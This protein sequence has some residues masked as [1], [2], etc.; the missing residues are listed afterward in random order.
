M[1]IY[2]QSA[3]DVHDF[4]WKVAP[5]Q[6]EEPSPEAIALYRRLSPFAT[7]MAMAAAAM[8]GEGYRLVVRSV[9]VGAGVNDVN[10]RDIYLNLCIEGL[11]EQQLRALACAYLQDEL[12]HDRHYWPLVTAHYQ[13]GNNYGMDWV[14]L[15]AAV[16][17]AANE[18]IG[19]SIPAEDKTFFSVPE[20]DAYLRSH[21]LPASN[22]EILFAQQRDNKEPELKVIVPVTQPAQIGRKWPLRGILSSGLLLVLLVGWWL[23]PGA[24]V[25]ETPGVSGAQNMEALTANTCCK[26][27][28][29]AVS[30][31]GGADAPRTT[32][33]CCTKC[34]AQNAGSD[35]VSPCCKECKCIENK[36]NGDKS[37][38]TTCCCSENKTITSQLKQ[39]P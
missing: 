36:Q 21:Q 38:K 27:C 28:K 3:G 30:K 15:Q 4:N 29:C 39:T 7:Q 6:V 31:E 18:P 32:C 10:S 16:E 8:P 1:K 13:E 14:A 12:R 2:I 19:G 5:G 33:Q 9:Y 23:A 35:A 22:G 25:E 37:S 17:K 24:S 26:E 20:L 34:N 11:T